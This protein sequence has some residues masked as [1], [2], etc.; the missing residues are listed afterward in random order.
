MRVH[1]NFRVPLLAV[2]FTLLEMCGDSPA[3]SA[4]HPHLLVRECRQTVHHTCPLFLAAAIS[5]FPASGSL[6]HFPRLGYL[7]RV[8]TDLHVR[9][10]MAFTGVTFVPSFANIG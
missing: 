9:C 3:D 1:R 7:S 10:R 2:Y 5:R 4:L 6:T 8:S